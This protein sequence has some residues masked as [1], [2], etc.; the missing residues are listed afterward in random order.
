MSGPIRACRDSR[1]RAVGQ[2]ARTRL[3]KLAT[4]ASRSLARAD[5]RA[6]HAVISSTAVAPC[7]TTVSTELISVEASAVWL[8]AV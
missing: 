5:S 2:A 3:K 7:V 8:A 4:F 1:E 6:V